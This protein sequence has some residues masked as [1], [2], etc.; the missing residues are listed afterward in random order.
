MNF[1]GA[2]YKWGGVNLT[3]LSNLTPKGSNIQKCMQNASLYSNEYISVEKIIISAFSF[4]S[5]C[6]YQA[7]NIRTLWEWYLQ[8][9]FFFWY[10]VANMLENGSAKYF[11]SKLKNDG[12]MASAWQ[13]QNIGQLPKIELSWS[14]IL[15]NMIFFYSIRTRITLYG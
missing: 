10:V 2:T 4:I 8:I 15:L 9:L 13:A 5:H 6:L 3:P 14:K 7:G 12:N 11:L 1:F